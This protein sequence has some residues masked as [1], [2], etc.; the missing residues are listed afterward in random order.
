MSTTLT[1][2]LIIPEVVSSLIDSNLGDGITLLPLAEQDDTLVGQ[3]GD[4]LKVE[5]LSIALAVAIM[6]IVFMF[7]PTMHYVMD[8]HFE[9]GQ[10]YNT[11]IPTTATSASEK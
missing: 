6:A 1:N 8:Q 4:T 3:P 2:N 11:V 5:I 7:R 10:N 9:I